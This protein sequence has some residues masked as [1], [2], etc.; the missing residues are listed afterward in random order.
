MNSLKLKKMDVIF[1]TIVYNYVI[2]LT[3]VIYCTTLET[4]NTFCRVWSTNARVSVY[5]HPNSFKMGGD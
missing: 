2:L 5:F 3:T 1:F 4:L